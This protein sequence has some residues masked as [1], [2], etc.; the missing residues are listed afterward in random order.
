MF[1]KKSYTEDDLVKGCIRN[2]R[3]HQEL[4]YKRFFDTM[5]AMVNKHCTDKDEAMEVLN[6]GFLRVFKKLYTF[7][8]KGSLEGWIRRIVYHAMT[9]HFS[10]QNKYHKFISLEE[11]SI[12]ISADQNVL[13]DLYQRD[14]ISIMSELPA[15]SR[16]VFEL[17]AIEGYTHKE[18]AEILGISDNTSKWHLAHARN[19]LKEAL[20][21]QSDEL[22]NIG[23]T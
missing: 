10:E 12:T 16:K 23:R 21:L 9:E 1:F 14:I 11:P 6:A 3:K 15:Q 13:S 5:F 18:I 17:Y 7:E 4:L 20:K 2:E 22:I 8:F 19:I